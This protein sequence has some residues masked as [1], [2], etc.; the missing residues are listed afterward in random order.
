M[1][2]IG[3]EGEGVFRTLLNRSTCTPGSYGLHDPFDD[4]LCNGVLTRVNRT[5]DALDTG[6][7]LVVSLYVCIVQSLH[8]FDEGRR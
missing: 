1:L 5:V 2:S 7:L 8:V 4:M 3:G 6:L